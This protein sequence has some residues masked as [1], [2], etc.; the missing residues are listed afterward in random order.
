[1]W[2]V[3]TDTD[4]SP[5]FLTA[6]LLTA[7]PSD[8]LTCRFHLGEFVNRFRQGSLVMRPADADSSLAAAPAL[9]FGTVNGVIGVVVTLQKAKYEFLLR[10]QVRPKPASQTRWLLKLAG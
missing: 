2:P 3:S 10:L 5:V 4:L 1:M 6:P 8:C 9:L 7:L